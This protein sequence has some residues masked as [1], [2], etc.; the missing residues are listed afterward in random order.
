MERDLFSQ[1]HDEYRAV[2]RDFL[3][4]EVEPHMSAWEQA[5]IVPRDLYRQLGELG[6][7]GI[8][9]PEEFG[10]A[11]ETT[12]LYNVVLAEEL[13]RLSV[14]FGGIGLHLDI[15]VPYFLDLANDEQRQRW[16]PGL[17]SGD[18]VTCIG[19]TEPGT[20]SDLAGISTTAVRDGD[21]YVVNGS[22]TFIT[23]GV[24]AELAVVV[25]RTGRADDRR[26][27]LSLLV[28]E[29]GTP[30]YDHSHKLDKLGMRATDTAELFFDS[31]RVPV[32]NL[33]GEEGKGFDYLTRNLPQERLSIG[34]GAIAACEA[35]LERTI[36]Y[37]HERSAFGKTIGT[38]QN[39]KF[40][41]AD[42]ASDIEAGRAMVDRAILALDKGRLSVA[43]AA[44]VKLFT[45]D[46][47]GEVM[48]RCLQLFGG[49]GFMREYPIAQMYA[50]SRVSRI[51]GGTNE[52]MKVIVA[53]SLGL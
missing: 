16:F 50:D 2:L 48:D 42:M 22:K 4:K 8:Q 34:V 38:F 46:L 19:M 24:N 25:V 13:S 23:G 49:Y 9:F 29:D 12:F 3:A 21:H 26:G 53:Q 10:G 43:D 52:I 31:V 6:T 39:T 7:M 11:G 27:G 14:H 15:V 32:A 20:G 18:L 37:V 51:Y 35:A 30:G 45:T 33:L 36:A 28:V 47:Q 41:L 1:E 5:G 44:K 40:E 17:A